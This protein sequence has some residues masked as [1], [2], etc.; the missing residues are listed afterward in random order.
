VHLVTGI[1]AAGK[2]TVAQALAERLPG[3]TVH[4]ST[5]ALSR[6]SNPDR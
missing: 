4:G 1:Q 5:E 3:R 6:T 2:S